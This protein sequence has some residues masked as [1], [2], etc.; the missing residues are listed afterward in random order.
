MT[1]IRSAVRKINKAFT[2][3]QILQ[4]FNPQK[5]IIMQS[6]ASGFA[7]SGILP[8]YDGF[9][10]LPQVNF[11]SRKCPPAEQNFHTKTLF[12]GRQSQGPD[13]V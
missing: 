10:I 6:D 2:E 3:T 11:Y 9:G 8:Q 1:F 13:P 7:I 12:Q 4:H 5:H